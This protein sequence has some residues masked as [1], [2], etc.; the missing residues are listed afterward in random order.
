MIYNKEPQEEGISCEITNNR[1]ENDFVNEIVNIVIESLLVSH[2]EQRIVEPLLLNAIKDKVDRRGN[3]EGLLQ[4]YESY[5][6]DTS[7]KKII[8]ELN[9]GDVSVDHKHASHA[10]F[11][12]IIKAIKEKITISNGD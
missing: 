12:S 2:R 1:I 3:N 10:K 4:Q 8:E 7:S 6:L 5:I 9:L 11:K